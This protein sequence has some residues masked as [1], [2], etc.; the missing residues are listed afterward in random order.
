MTFLE[1]VKAAV[2]AEEAR[3]AAETPVVEEA[4]VAPEVPVETVEAPVEPTV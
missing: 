3:V 1:D 2:A 4:E